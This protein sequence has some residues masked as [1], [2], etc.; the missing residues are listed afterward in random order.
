VQPAT[1]DPQKMR[2]GSL[3]YNYAFYCFN[4][5]T[6]LDP[7]YRVQPELATSWEATKDLKIWTFHLRPNVKFHNGKV[8]DAK[9]VVFT[10]ARQ[11]QHRQQHRPSSEYW[12]RRSL[13][14]ATALCSIPINYLPRHE[15]AD[16][17]HSAR[18][19]IFW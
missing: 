3:E 19:P 15:F 14:S 12:R 10:P 6:A 16:V 5:L 4:R 18:L 2:V 9:D 11:F 7:H 13:R 1:L 8:L 17:S